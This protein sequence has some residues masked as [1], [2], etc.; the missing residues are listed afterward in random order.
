MTGTAGDY[1]LNAFAGGTYLVIAR[2]TGNAELPG[3]VA[4]TK[5]IACDPGGT[6][7]VDLQLP[8]PVTLPIR[9]IDAAG[10][11]VP[12]AKLVTVQAT[13]P[14]MLSFADVVGVTDVEGRSVV[15]SF[16]PG[17]ECW[18]EVSKPGYIRASTAKHTGSP[19]EVFP[20]E[21]L[22]LF[23]TAG[24]QGIALGPDGAPLT[25]KGIDIRVEAADYREH[26]NQYMPLDPRGAFTLLEGVPAAN[27]TFTLTLAQDTPAATQ[28]LSAHVGPIDC[29]PGVVTDLGPITFTPKPE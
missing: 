9:V 3:S 7:E 10:Q 20:E 25:A 5:E 16:T 2:Y 6:Y 28:D 21:T 27:V 13:A 24:I 12:G 23:A 15:A 29:A 18:L 1:K 19:G 26:H 8:E 4:S 22:V 11:P 17:I 14:Q